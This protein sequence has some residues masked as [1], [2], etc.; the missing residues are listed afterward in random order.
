VLFLCSKLGGFMD[1]KELLGNDLYAQVIA[2]T[3]DKKIDV[4]DENYVIKQDYDKLKKDID[5]LKDEKKTII[6]DRDTQLKDLA[7]K[8]KDNEEVKKAFEELKKK[9]DEDL[10][11]Y[12]AKMQ[13]IRFNSSLE[14]ALMAYNT[15]DIKAIFPYIDKQILKQNDDDSITGLDEQMKNLQKDKSFLFKVPEF[16]TPKP[17]FPDPNKNPPQESSFGTLIAKTRNEQ[18]KATYDPWAI[19]KE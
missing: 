6:Q 7:D 19:K 14:K 4:I 2:K 11:S 10:K 16:Q 18:A 13:E 1:L 5:K 3:G 12:E 8:A 17:A 15:Y 9:N